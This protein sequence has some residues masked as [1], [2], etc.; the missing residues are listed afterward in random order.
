MAKIQVGGGRLSKEAEAEFDR[1]FP[2][3]ARK[4]NTN[5]EVIQSSGNGREPSTRYYSSSSGVRWK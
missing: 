2:R 5:E 4:E 1:L 3:A